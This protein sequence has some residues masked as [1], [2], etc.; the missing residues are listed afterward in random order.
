MSEKLQIVYYT[1][2]KD[3]A[4]LLY[5][6][7]QSF[8]F[9]MTAKTVDAWAKVGHGLKD[10]PIGTCG[11]IDGKLAGFVG[12]LE[13]PTRS[14]QGDVEMVGGIWAIATR[15]SMARQGVGRKLLEAAENHFRERGIRLSMLTTSRSIV[16]HRWYSGVGYREVEVVNQYPHYY[17]VLKASPKLKSK[18]PLAAVDFDRVQCVAN[19]TRFMKDRCGF[20][21]RAQERFDYMETVGNLGKGT[22]KTTERG[23]VIAST[24]MGAAMVNEMIAENQTA[25]LEM[26]KW[27][28]S[29]VEN[30]VYYRYVFDPMVAKALTKAGYRS[31]TGAFDVFMCKPLGNVGFD[32]VYDESFTVSRG[33]FF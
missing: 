1:D 8:G 2:L 23:H 9:L 32:D 6:W 13:L 11:L 5:L 30:G 12:M 26:I 16:A 20:V 10:T 28:E 24:Q 22:S 27:V 7:A 17:K 14:K 3:K 25:A 29:C 4:D 15:P 18:K 21:Y 33:E 19:F 31:D